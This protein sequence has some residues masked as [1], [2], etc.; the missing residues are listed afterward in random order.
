[1]LVKQ[2]IILLS[3]LAGRGFR[4]LD[5]FKKSKWPRN[6]HLDLDRLSR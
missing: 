1:M 2:F 5:P 3:I 4:G 6:I